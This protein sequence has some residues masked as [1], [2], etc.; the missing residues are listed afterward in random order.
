MS[1]RVLAS[2]ALALAPVLPSS[3]TVRARHLMFHYKN[4]C[5]L[6]ARFRQSP[7]WFEQHTRPLRPGQKVGQTFPELFP[8]AG[9][10]PSRH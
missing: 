4:M 3:Y 5:Q 6:P 2:A 10:L 8:N 1:G 7:V 9:T